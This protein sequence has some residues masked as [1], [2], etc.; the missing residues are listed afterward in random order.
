M[1]LCHLR[2]AFEAPPKPH[3]HAA[4]SARCF[5]AT[6]FLLLN[7]PCPSPPLSPRPPH[8]HQGLGHMV[9]LAGSCATCCSQVLMH[10]LNSSLQ[11][12]FL[13]FNLLSPSHLPPLPH[14]HQGLGRMF[15]CHLR[16]T[17]VSLHVIDASSQPPVFAQFSFPSLTHYYLIF[18]VWVACFF[19]TCAAPG[20][21]CTCSTHL[22]L[23]PF[24]TTW[25]YNPEYTSRPHILVLNKIDLP[26]VRERV[27]DLIR[28]ILQLTSSGQADDVSITSK[29]ASSPSSS[30]S[31]SYRSCPPSSPPRAYTDEGSLSRLDNDWEDSRGGGDADADADVNGDGDVSMDG[32]NADAE[33]STT[34]RLEP[35]IAIVHISARGGIVCFPWSHQRQRGVDHLLVAVREAVEAE[36][37]GE[38]RGGIASP[39]LTRDRDA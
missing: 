25:M 27:P 12:P 5:F 34:E 18:R 10:V 30:P 16:R 2:R 11:P 24:M 7:L 20:C 35:P 31:S 22:R 23:T 3:P 26:E 13:C 29:N 37:R 19:A 17:P 8:S 21:C 9:W 33:A 36:R 38:L 14:Y 15:L 1:F 6:T 32:A 39:D 4:A 28:Q